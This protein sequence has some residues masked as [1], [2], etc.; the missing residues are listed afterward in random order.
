MTLYGYTCPDCRSYHKTISG[1]QF[2]KRLL[3]VQCPSCGEVE[4]IETNTGV[5]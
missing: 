5:V 1:Y 4:E 3:S 2:G